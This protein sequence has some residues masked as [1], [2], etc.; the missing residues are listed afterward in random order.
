MTSPRFRALPGEHRKVYS[1]RSEADFVMPSG[2][3][4]SYLILR[5]VVGRGFLNIYRARIRQMP[6]GWALR[7]M[8]R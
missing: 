2:I 1:N 4:T 6:F 8:V 5:Y 3:I 7:M